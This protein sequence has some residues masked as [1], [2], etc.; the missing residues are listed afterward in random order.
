[1]HFS[2]SEAAAV[3]TAGRREE[4]EASEMNRGK[5]GGQTSM[6][7]NPFLAVLHNASSQRTREMTRAIVLVEQKY[8]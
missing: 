1:M 5:H 7:N 6:A 3:M 2:S 8:K 4:R